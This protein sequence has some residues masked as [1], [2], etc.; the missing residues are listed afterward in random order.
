[1]NV[2]VAHLRANRIE[3]FRSAVEQH[4]AA[5]QSPQVVVEAAVHASHEALRALVKAGAD[6]NRPWRGYRPLHALIQ[7]RP[8]GDTT[9]PDRARIACLSWMLAHGAD[10]ELTGAWP[11]A[12]ALIVAAFAGQPAFVNALVDGGAAVTP[13]VAA[14]L[15]DARRIRRELA[16]D[17]AAA[18]ARDD[19]GLTMLQCAAGSRMWIGNRAVERSLLAIVARLHEHG[20]DPLAK[21]KSWDHDIDALYLAVA[22]GHQ[23]IYDWLLAHGADPDEA[24]AACLWRHRYGWAEA[25]LARGAQPDRVRDGDHPLL[26]NLVRWGQVEAALWLLAR[27]ASPNLPD[28]RGVTAAHRAVSRRNRRLL[29]AIVAAGG[30]LTEV[31]GVG[32]PEG[33]ERPESQPICLA[34][35]CRRDRDDRPE[36]RRVSADRFR[37]PPVGCD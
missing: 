19:G 5:A 3:A 14:T 33:R 23:G 8:H 21:T 26:N 37:R 25:A 29:E 17:P 18:R 2:L 10:P 7:E 16:R 31:H 30:T 6:L 22:S 27:G 28:A 32:Y 9:P 4:P 11:P 34:V 20:A 13:F 15:G 24:L 1:V 35:H 36:D 12:R